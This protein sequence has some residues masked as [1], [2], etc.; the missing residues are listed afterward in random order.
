MSC[1]CANQV[2]PSATAPDPTKHVSFQ[3]GMVLG[4]D[5]LNQEYAYHAERLRWTTRDLVGYGTA[6]GLRVSARD[7]GPPRG[8]EIVIAPGVA[9]NPRG[10]LIRVAPTQCA[11]LNDWLA[12]RTDDVVKR[13]L[14]TSNPNVFDLPL[15]V[16]V[17]YRDC[18]TDPVPIAG[19]P[20]RS[21]GD[22]TK[23]SR[24]ADDFLLE[25]TFD[26]PPQQEEDADREF[27]QWLRSHIAVT[28]DAGASLTIGQ[29]LDGLRAAADAAAAPMV[30]PPPGPQPVL[31]EASPPSGLSVPASAVPDYLRAALRLWVTELRPRWRPNW[32]GD[33][34]GC[35]GGGGLAATDQGNQVLLAALTVPIVPPGL[36][37]AGFTVTSAADVVIAEDARPLLLPTRLLE[38]L[39]IVD[40]GGGAPGLGGPVVVAAGVVNGNGSAN[41]RSTVS[42]LRVLSAAGTAS[43]TELKLAFNTYINPPTSGGPQYIVKT[44]P[45]PSG[46]AI[47]N[48]CVSFGG[49]QSDGFLLE[50]SADGGPLSAPQLNGLQLMVE[51]SQYS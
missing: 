17:S 49:F 44:T 11:S 34:G 18:Q 2:Q 8:P 12:A 45:W 20:C 33:K 10:Q 29:F 50:L 40:N 39:L 15:Y 35:T 5:D 25:L 51:V 13:R 37:A 3:L 36:G 6:W 7:D 14:P 38:E 26:P 30:S 24:T 42:G 46:P 32:L 27:V 48:L 19:E 21:E 28:E 41:G 31:I 22:S 1:L 4:V 47:N 16:V 23:P 43:A 9:I